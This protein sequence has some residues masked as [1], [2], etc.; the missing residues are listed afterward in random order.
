MGRV[1]RLTLMVLCSH[2]LR[3][4]GSA[5]EF[6]EAIVT[7]LRK[8]AVLRGR[9]RR[10]EYWYFRLFVFLLYVIAILVTA[11]YGHGNPTALERMRYDD[12]R[13]GLLVMVYLG[14]FLPMCAV[15]VRR[16]HDLSFSTWWL[17]IAAVPVVGL[18]TLVVF[19][20]LP[21]SPAENRYGPDPKARR[22]ATTRAVPY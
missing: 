19:Y 6:L 14:T 2:G 12:V 16:L 4:A 15:T 22:G 10:S 13:N 5:M 8:Y 20:C 7:C 1:D 17:L 21:G 11:N 9:A 18:L 3:A